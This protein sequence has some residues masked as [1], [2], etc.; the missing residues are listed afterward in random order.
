M[1][2]AFEHMFRSVS[3]GL[4]VV[5][6]PV[7]VLYGRQP[8]VNQAITRNQIVV[9]RGPDKFGPPPAAGGNPR[10]VGARYVGF[11]AKIECASTAPGATELE[12]TSLAESILHQ[13]YCA[14]RRWQVLARSTLEFSSGGF[15]EP[16]SPIDVGAR[17]ELTGYIG[18]GIKEQPWQEISGVELEGSGAVVIGGVET[19]AC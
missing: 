9:T 18:E 15:I 5:G 11:K 17:Y 7:V 13:L 10:N 19:P 6:V 8:A 2:F 1:I 12:H 14:L 4:E 3:A 16:A